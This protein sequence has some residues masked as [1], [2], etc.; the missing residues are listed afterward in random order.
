MKYRISTSNERVRCTTQ[1][2]TSSFNHSIGRTHSWRFPTFYFKKSWKTSAVSSCRIATY[3]LGTFEPEET[4]MDACKFPLRYDINDFCDF[5]SP[6]T[7]AL[8][9]AWVHVRVLYPPVVDTR[10]GE[11]ALA[12]VRTVLDPL[13][14]RTFAHRMCFVC[15]LHYKTFCLPNDIIISSTP[16]LCP[17]RFFILEKYKWCGHRDCETEKV[18]ELQ[19]VSYTHLTLPTKA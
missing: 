13:W 19:P 16:C 6:S 3:M 11:K 5:S 8:R 10:W 1:L 15:C 18:C 14:F 2:A 4:S 12:W 17:S 7:G 9:L